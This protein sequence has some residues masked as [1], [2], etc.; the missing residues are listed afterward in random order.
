MKN[1][2]PNTQ[3]PSI[4]VIGFGAFGELIARHTAGRFKVLV[5]D[6]A[7]VSPA[8]AHDLGVVPATFESAAA[9]DIVVIATPVSCFEEVLTQVAMHCRPGALVMDVGSVKIEPAALMVKI[10]PDTVHVAAT[11][12]LFGPQSARAGLAGLKMAICPIRGDAHA[13][14]AAF[15]RERLGLQVIV[16]TPEDHDR[17]AATVQGLT[18]LIGKV[19]TRMGPLPTRMTTRSFDLLVEAIAMIKDDAP[20]VFDAI[21]NS[22]PY[23][24]DVRRRF[25]QLAHDLNAELGTEPQHDH[26]REPIEKSA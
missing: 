21:E 17:E 2:K 25:F 9:C 18:H 20:E 23:S 3:P 5:Y 12:P 16:T 1:N 4:G 13:R 14:L 10:L 7:P 11:H 15:L 24:P 19:L 6:A 22:N 26:A 8:K